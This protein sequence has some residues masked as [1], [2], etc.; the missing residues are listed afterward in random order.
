M[1]VTAWLAVLERRRKQEARE[2]Y[3]DLDHLSIVDEALIYDT[4]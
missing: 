3:G 1:V 4:L 2:T